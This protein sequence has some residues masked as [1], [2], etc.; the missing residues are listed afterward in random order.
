MIE[1]LY[2]KEELVRIAKS[3]MPSK[4]PSRWSERAVC[5]VERD[6]M[7]G[8]FI[9][10]RLIEMDKLSSQTTKKKVSVFSYRTIRQINKLSRFSLE[11]NYDWVN[12]VSH[13]KTLVYIANQFIHSYISEVTRDSTRNWSDILIVSDFDRKDRIWRIPIAQLSRTF[14]IASSDWPHELHYKL[15]SEKGD[16]VVRTN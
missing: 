16:Y 8:F 14:I 13:E 4:K 2:W 3:L 5:T 10:R 1:S 12:E 6:V 15:D 7:I 9:L 11:R